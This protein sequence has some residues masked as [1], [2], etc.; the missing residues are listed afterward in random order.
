MS[1]KRLEIENAETSFKKT[2]LLFYNDNY[3][4]HYRYY[5]DTLQKLYPH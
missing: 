5:G 4:N 1:R 2:K 3:V